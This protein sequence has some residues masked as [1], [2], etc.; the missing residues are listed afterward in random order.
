[1]K[2]AV[3]TNTD[4]VN[5]YSRTLHLSLALLCVRPSVHHFILSLSPFFYSG[6][7]V[8]VW[9]S[10]AFFFSIQ[11]FYLIFSLGYVFA[12]LALVFCH[13]CRII[14]YSNVFSIPEEDGIFLMCFPC[15]DSAVWS[16][17]LYL[18]AL[19][20]AFSLSLPRMLFSYSIAMPCIL[21][22]VSG[23]SGLVK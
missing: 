10:T 2:Y 20:L 22:L 11:F 14:S 16:S 1:M 15:I 12:S 4:F 5:F 13:F 17:E 3:L 8:I 7:P 21:A 23:I 9:T 19:V 18:V 6:Y